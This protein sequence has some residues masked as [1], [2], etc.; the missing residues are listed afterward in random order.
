MT[1]LEDVVAE[2]ALLARTRLEAHLNLRH[3]LA[4]LEAGEYEIAE[5]DARKALLELG[6]L[7]R[8]VKKGEKRRRAK[9]VRVP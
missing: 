9:G 2:L 6:K 1:G 3:A 4:R 5:E 8:K 7:R